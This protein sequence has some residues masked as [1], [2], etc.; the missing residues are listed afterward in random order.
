MIEEKVCIGQWY[1]LPKVFN[2]HGLTAEQVKIPQ[3]VMQ[4]IVSDYTREA[5]VRNL[6]RQLA[7]ICRKAA[8][9]VIERPKTYLRL[10]TNTLEQYLGPRRYKFTLADQKT[11]IDNA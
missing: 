5:G 9:R 6:E 10:T 1:L 2:E 11:Q 4:H 8:R 3:S 7:T